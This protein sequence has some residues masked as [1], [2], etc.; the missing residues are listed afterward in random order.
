MFK[1]EID[2]LISPDRLETVK[3]RLYRDIQ[4]ARPASPPNLR[5]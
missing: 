2:R 4:A 3:T 5:I 1:F